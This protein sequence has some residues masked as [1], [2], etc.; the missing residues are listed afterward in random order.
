MSTFRSTDRTDEELIEQARSWPRQGYGE[1]EWFQAMADRMEM[2]RA[3]LEAITKRMG[4]Y[5]RDAHTFACNVIDSNV[6]IATK[7]LENRYE[8]K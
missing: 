2:M 3:A 7:A 6:E 8:Y 1:G 5:N 4:A